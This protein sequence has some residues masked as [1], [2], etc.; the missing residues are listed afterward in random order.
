MQYFFKVKFVVLA[1]AL[2]LN[3]ILIIAG[4]IFFVGFAIAAIIYRMHQHNMRHTTRLFIEL[5]ILIT[6]LRKAIDRIKLFKKAEYSTELELHEQNYLKFREIITKIQTSRIGNKKLKTIFDIEKNMDID[7][8]TIKR[9]V[10]REIKIL[11][12]YIEVF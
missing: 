10:R 2:R 3:D 12:T 8:D 11:L 5:E 4:G 1:L 6:D 9:Q 7:T